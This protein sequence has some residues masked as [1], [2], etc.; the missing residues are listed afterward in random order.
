M[1]FRNRFKSS[2]NPFMKE[3]VL[4]NSTQEVS[5]CVRGG[6]CFRGLR[7]RHP[8]AFAKQPMGESSG[9]QAMCQETRRVNR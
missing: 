2:S 1:A 9:T 3:E 4:R 7:W 5:P 6:I 8:R